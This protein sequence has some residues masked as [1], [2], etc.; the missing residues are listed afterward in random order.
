MSAA[1]TRV[2]VVTGGNKGIG[3][4]VVRAIAKAANF[5]GDVYLTSRDAKRGLEAV[6]ALMAEGL[7]VHF[8][9]LDILDKGSIEKLR[10]FMDGKYGGIDVLVNNA[11]IA[12]KGAATEPFAEQAEVSIRTNF[13]AVKDTCHLLFPVLKSGA[14]VVNVSSCEGFLP[15]IRGKEPAAGALRRKFA[16]SGSTLTAAELGQM[17]EDF[18]QA[19]KDG[20]H[21]ER[22]WPNSTYVVSK[23][24]LSALTR[25]QQHE[26]DVSD[27]E[28]HNDLVVSHVHPG[29]VDTDMT[30]H[31]GPLT[32]DQGARSAV[33]A[34]LLPPLTELKGRYFWDNCQEVDWVNGPTP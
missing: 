15:K 25:I 10:D 16:L 33:F 12:F 22:G 20:T 2:A 30:S 26:F 18:V 6:N 5:S 21:H 29:Y 17:M 8:H 1:A 34:A 27:P 32:I 13:W 28:G 7:I 4:G 11:G 9:Q 3:L 31:K 14:R 24:G 23:V 19:A